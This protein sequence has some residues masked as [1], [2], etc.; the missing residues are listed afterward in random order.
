MLLLSLIVT[1]R[2]YPLLPV[3]AAPHRE[4]VHRRAHRG[5]RVRQ[6]LHLPPAQLEAV[7]DVLLLLLKVR[8][9][10]VERDVVA[11]V[12]LRL[13]RCGERE[14]RG[15]AGRAGGGGR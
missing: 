7:E 14:E 10:G 4:Q 5:E 15:G 2:Y 1:T 11:R 12:R 6:C 3:N 9:L 13:S 8:K